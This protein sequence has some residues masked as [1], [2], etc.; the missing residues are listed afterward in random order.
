MNTHFN[1]Q[2][3]VLCVLLFLLEVCF[4]LYLLQ[5]APEKYRNLFARVFLL[6]I[7][8]SFAI[9]GYA[10]HYHGGGLSALLYKL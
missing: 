4:M 7:L 5:K 1:Y 9:A 10:I 2:F 6:L 3:V 8:S